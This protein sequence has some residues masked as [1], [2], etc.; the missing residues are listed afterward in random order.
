MFRISPMTKTPTSLPRLVQELRA[1]CAAIGLIT[2]TTALAV[3][4][5]T[6]G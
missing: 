3:L 2:V 6:F 4:A 5:L 1:L